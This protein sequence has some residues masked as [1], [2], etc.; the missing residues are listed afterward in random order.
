MSAFFLVVELLSYVFAIYIFLKKKELAVMYLP[1]LFFANSMVN[2]VLPASV[3]YL[4]VSFIIFAFIFWNPSYYKQNLPALLLSLYFL[5]LLP[6]SSDIVYIRPY[7][8][9]VFWLFTLIP[10]ISTLYQK[11]T[12]KVIFKELTSTALILLVLFTC[13]VLMSTVKGYSPYEMYG[14]SSGIL[15]GNVYAAGFNVLTFAIYIV[16]LG[17]IQNKSAVNLLV[18]VVT[19]S[20][21]LLSL[22][23]SVMGISLLGILISYLTILTVDKAKT[24]VLFGF[25]AVA[26]GCTVYF[27]TD[28]ADSF[29]ERYELRKLDERELEEEKRFIE[30]ELLYKD[31]FVYRD[32]SPLTGF[33]LFNSWGNYGRGALDDRSLHGDLTSI[34]HSSGL[35]GLFL[36]LLMVFSAFRTSWKAA[37]TRTDYLTILFCGVAFIVFTITGRYTEV[38]AMMMLFLVLQLP[39][40]EDETET[41]DIEA[42]HN[43][44][45]STLQSSKLHHV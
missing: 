24:F 32:Y 14:I 23:R 9:A 19:F 11:Y 18:L 45:H 1:V 30:Y 33:E 40:A 42:T 16:A 37:Q 27:T 34:T 6:Q 4:T 35:I 12:K 26:L 20:F 39:L 3:F 7:L 29:K 15:Y 43:A 31:M 41:A 8:F 44:Q 17:F 36:Y 21:I 38:G 13:N 5:V 10:C 22:R 25:L 28:L 2:P